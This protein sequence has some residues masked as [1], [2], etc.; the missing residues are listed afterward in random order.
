MH[1]V[2]AEGACTAAIRSDDETATAH[3]AAGDVTRLRIQSLHSHHHQHR[4]ARDEGTCRSV[5]VWNENENCNG[6]NRKPETTLFT[7][8]RTKKIG[9][10][11]TRSE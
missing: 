7:K 10:F 11:R 1:R 5:A 4:G 9:I 3:L 8:I 2:R 6:E